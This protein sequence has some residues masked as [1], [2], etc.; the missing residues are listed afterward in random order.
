MP[1][2]AEIAP[3]GSGA[4]DENGISLR[5]LQRWQQPRQWQRRTTAKFWSEKFTW[6]FH[7]GELKSLSKSYDQ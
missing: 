2:L 4:D 6:A 3:S 5:Q 1:S 7:S